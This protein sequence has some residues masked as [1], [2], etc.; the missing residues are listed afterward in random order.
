MK[1]DV[2]ISKNS[3]DQELADSVV[4]FLEEAGLSVFESKKDLPRLGDADYSRAIF[5]A[6]DNAK[7]IVIICSSNENGACSKWVYEEWSWFINEIRSKRRDGQI[8]TIRRGIAIDKIDAQLRKY[9]S[10]EYDVYQSRILPYFGKAL[11]A[12][13]K[14][15]Q[16][17]SVS[18]PSVELIQKADQIDYINLLFEN[19]KKDAFSDE[20]HNRVLCDSFV[21]DIIHMRHLRVSRAK[22][23]IKALAEHGDTGA[24]YAM[25]FL[26]SYPY[27]TNIRISGDEH[28]NNAISWLE[29]AAD[30]G[31][32]KAQQQLASVYYWGG[33]KQKSLPYAKAAAD[34]G[35]I[36]AAIIYSW[37]HR[38]LKNFQEYAHALRRAATI[39]KETHSTNIHCPAL[40]YGILLCDGNAV[41]KDLKQSIEWFDVA[42]KYA[43]D[44]DQKDNAL[45]YKSKALFELGHK[46]KA[47]NALDKTYEENTKI[48]SLRKTILA[49]IN[50]F[51][52]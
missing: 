10:F 11:A 20:Y 40:D 51:K 21:D 39:Q 29:K 4:R 41:P 1:Y 32:V 34:K 37:A 48:Q 16:E 36:D 26:E 12:P 50:P 49:A 3:N 15:S 33:E 14:P 43:Y 25:G 44:L 6:L 18:K 35:N 19:A 7:N 47:L 52:K 27:S 8:M 45:Y 22:P 17:V 46:L 23:Q 24:E 30:K 9:E 38:D 2:F 5:N 28:Y 31:H 13:T 42:I